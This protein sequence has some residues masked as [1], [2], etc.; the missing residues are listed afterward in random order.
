LIRGQGEI[1]RYFD[2]PLL[3]QSDHKPVFAEILFHVQRVNDEQK[4]I[5]TCEII[6]NAKKIS[7][8]H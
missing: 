4:S 7:D 5:V 1:L 6:E 8:F 3:F 2:F